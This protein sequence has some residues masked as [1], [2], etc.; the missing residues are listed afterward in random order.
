MLHKYTKKNIYKKPKNNNKP[1]IYTRTRK[2]GCNVEETC[3]ENLLDLNS[4][5]KIYKSNELKKY[6]INFNKKVT[7]LMLFIKTKNKFKPT[8]DYYNYIN[9]NWI[10]KVSVLHNQ[11]YITKI[12]NF[13]LV[14]D[15]V[16]NQINDIYNNLITTNSTSKEIINM[17]EFYLS[18]KNL[19][20]KEQ[21]KIY[22]NNYIHK[23]DN[24]INDP[25]NNNLWKL[26]ALISKNKMIA[27]DA[28][29]SFNMSPNEKK[30]THYCVH[31]T[32]YSVHADV[33]MYLDQYNPKYKFISNKYIEY[34]NT[35]LDITGNKDLH[36]HAQDIFDVEKDIIMC[37][38]TTNFNNDPDG[39]NKVYTD[40]ALEKY[41][42]NFKEYCKELGFKTIPEYFVISNLDYLKNVCELMLQNWKTPKWRTYWI[43]MF[44]RQIIRYT[45]DYKS[46]CDNFYLKLLKGQDNDYTD[47]IRA[48]RFTL[49][50]YNKLLSELYITQYTN[51][52]SIKYLTNMCVD[53][54]SVCYKM[55]KNN[56][57]LD[58]KT[59]QQALLKL[60]YLKIIIG[61]SIDSIDDPDLNYINNDIWHNMLSYNEWKH[62]EYLVLND[63]PVKN[64]PVIN[65]DEYPFVYSGSQSFIVNANY[66][67]ITNSIYI[68]LAYI[69]EP[70]IS[71]TNDAS[72][73]YN[74]ANIGFTIA[75]E[76]SHSLDN[77]GSRYD[78][79]GNL[80]NWWTSKDM[81]KYNEIQ[82]NIKKHYEFV[83]K[84]DGLTI[85][86]SSNLR[87]NISDIVGLNICTQYYI[88]FL[89]K[90]NVE[91]S[92][93]KAIIE[94]F[95]IYFALQMREKINKKSIQYYINM[96]P[97]S[98][99]K[100]R[101]NVPLSRNEIFTSLYNVKK[102][103]KMYYPNIKSI[104]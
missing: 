29:L 38:S 59:K 46:I 14:Q 68:P 33:N 50:S 83:N 49:I 40:E 64:I 17:R 13:R 75:H 104:F 2:Y 54:K 30:T 28:P 102:G 63:S 15:K 79:N 4:F 103:D 97:H 65:W 41:R 1:N 24:L 72:L 86:A 77:I 27:G 85:N 19:I 70:F 21:C 94:D 57:W 23:I 88:D 71:L 61:E 39:Y 11:K 80:T 101:V 96:N 35:Y 47:E 62:N 18:A 48:I 36:G 87:E 66:T 55:I 84:R 82:E 92:S 76:L 25:N 74:L 32:P 93:L 9:Y 56:T 69:Q 3:N 99:D 12:D 90:T 26:L 89:N 5:E 20:S 60:D 98:S 42:F 67:S 22:I 44:V 31:I 58:P 51:A 52:N 73:D 95:F 78:Y 43:K 7:G 10:N 45:Y 6:N 37:F 34:I 53:L 91:L 8:D 100:Y 16:Y 81:K